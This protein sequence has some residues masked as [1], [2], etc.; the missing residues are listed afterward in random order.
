MRIVLLNYKSLCCRRQ[1]RRATLCR[2]GIAWPHD[3]PSTSPLAA[4]SYTCRFGCTASSCASQWLATCNP[5]G[6]SMALPLLCRIVPRRRCLR[7]RWPLAPAPAAPLVRSVSLWCLPL[8]QKHPCRLLSGMVAW[9]DTPQ[10]RALLSSHPPRTWPGSRWHGQAQ[11]AVRLGDNWSVATARIATIDP[12]S[13]T[14][15]LAAPFFIWTAASRPDPP[16]C[17]RRPRG[18][19]QSNCCSVC[20]FKAASRLGCHSLAAAAALAAAVGSSEGPTSR[21]ACLRRGSP[22]SPLVNSTMQHRWSLRCP[23]ISL[24]LALLLA[25]P[26]VP[27]GAAPQ[28]AASAGAP[29]LAA[30]VAAAGRAGGRLTIA[31]YQLEGEPQPDTLELQSFEVG[32]LPTGWGGDGIG[33]GDRAAGYTGS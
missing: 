1:G 30:A 6:Q 17:Q 19:R 31:G 7:R 4:A 16:C 5:S 8:E 10:L 22:S 20:S 33:A 15:R 2:P 26:P 12:P 28:V 18:R 25:L 27:A 13:C 32:C 21:P 23:A 11:E 24:A 29:A 3:R 9:R 14:S